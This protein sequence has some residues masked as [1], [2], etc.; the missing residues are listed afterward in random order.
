MAATIELRVGDEYVLAAIWGAIF[1]PVRIFNP[2]ER[3]NFGNLATAGVFLG[4]SINAT[5]GVGV[6]QRECKGVNPAPAV[7]VYKVAWRPQ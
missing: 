7:D 6:N 1:A 3:R 4:H 2:S 5:R